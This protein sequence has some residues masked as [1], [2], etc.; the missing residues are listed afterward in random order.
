M[1]QSC[2]FAFKLSVRVAAGRREAYGGPSGGGIVLLCVKQA[3]GQTVCQLR[4]SGAALQLVTEPCQRSSPDWHIASTGG[5]WGHREGGWGARSCSVDKGHDVG[6]KKRTRAFSTWL[7]SYVLRHFLKFCVSWGSSSTHTY[8]F[9]MR[10]W[11]CKIGHK[12]LNWHG[13]KK[14]VLHVLHKEFEAS[15]SWNKGNKV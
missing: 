14:N 11:L 8:L 6:K 12:A 15:V 7:N 13:Q 2:T 9:D 1:P 10:F 3:G 5:G 4:R